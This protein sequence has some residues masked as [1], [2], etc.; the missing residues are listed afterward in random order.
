MLI[1]IRFD[2]FYAENVKI[3]SLYNEKDAAEAGIDLDWLKRENL[4]G[5]IMVSKD[6]ILLEHHD[7]VIGVVVQHEKPTNQFIRTS[8]I[9]MVVHTLGDFA[10]MT[11][12]F[13]QNSRYEVLA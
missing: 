4:T 5:R 8:P 11:I 13:T 7:R 1:P 3:F 10:K 6:T 12:V 9:Q 2:G